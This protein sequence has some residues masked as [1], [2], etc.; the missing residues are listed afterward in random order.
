VLLSVSLFRT[1][2]SLDEEGAFD[3]EL[4]WKHSIAVAHL[5]K[6]IARDF[7]IRTH[8]EEFTAGLLHDSG[9]IIIAQYFEETL[10]DMH[11][12]MEQRGIPIY[13]AE[14]QVLGLSHMD[15]GAWLADKWKIPEHLTETIRYHHHPHLVLENPLLTHLVCLANLTANYLGIN[16]DPPPAMDAVVSHESWGVIGGFS[17]LSSPVDVAAYLESL[18]QEKDEVDKYMSIAFV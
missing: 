6:K 16:V 4:F 15:I 13:E 9:K 10:T 18:A 8:G 7:R 11:V 12:A 2:G 5:A 3:Q 1:F 14:E 17:G